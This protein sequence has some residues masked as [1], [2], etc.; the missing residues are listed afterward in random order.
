MIEDL[1]FSFLTTM[2]SGVQELNKLLNTLRP[3]NRNEKVI[4]VV[5]SRCIVQMFK[6]ATLPLRER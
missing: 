5:T 4:T 3:E 2:E 6:S 1:L